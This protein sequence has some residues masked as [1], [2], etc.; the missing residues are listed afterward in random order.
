[1]LWLRR[2]LPKAF[3]AFA[4]I[5]SL[6][7]NEEKKNQPKHFAVST[8]LSF[9]SRAHIQNRLDALSSAKD[10][11]KKDRMKRGE[12]RNKSNSENLW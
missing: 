7:K 11:V 1:M 8:I 3:D 12:K 6:I 5:F 9:G 4:T 10:E 2:D